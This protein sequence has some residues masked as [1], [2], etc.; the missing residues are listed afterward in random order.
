MESVE[1]V[2]VRRVQLEEN[3]A[4]LRKDLQHWRTWDAEYEGLKEELMAVDDDADEQQL[5]SE[6]RYAERM[7]VV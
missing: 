6:S 3:V 7:E 2:E 5:V 1:L 4:K